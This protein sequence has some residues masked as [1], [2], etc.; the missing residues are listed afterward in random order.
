MLCFNTV[1]YFCLDLVIEVSSSQKV[2]GV[3]YKRVP[4]ILLFCG[5]IQAARPAQSVWHSS[6]SQ[7]ALCPPAVSQGKG[8]ARSQIVTE[9]SLLANL[10]VV[11]LGPFGSRLQP[12]DLVAI[13]FP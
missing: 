6:C 12:N 10:L 8:C 9:Q 1:V 3:V 5:S 2:Q 4:S 7:L 11:S 13:L